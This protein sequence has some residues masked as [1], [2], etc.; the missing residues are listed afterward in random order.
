MVR[1]AEKLVDRIAEPCEFD[2]TV[3]SI[4]IS[5]GIA[6][7]PTDGETADILIKGLGIDHMLCLEFNQNLAS[8]SPEDFVVTAPRP[9]MAPT[10]IPSASHLKLRTEW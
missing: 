3:L 7:Y 9:V 4:T 10:T 1:L 6:I 5:I 8:M 2:G